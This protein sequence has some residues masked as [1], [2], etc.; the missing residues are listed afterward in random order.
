MFLFVFLKQSEMCSTTKKIACKSLQISKTFISK[1]L[2]KQT[3]RSGSHQVRN[4]FDSWKVPFC[5]HGDVIRCGWVWVVG[6]NGY[7]FAQNDGGYIWVWVRPHL[8]MGMGTNG[9]EMDLDDGNPRTSRVPK[10]L[11]AIQTTVSNSERTWSLGG[12]LT[13]K[14]R[15]RA[16]YCYF[17]RKFIHKR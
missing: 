12:C 17:Q 1:A 13:R 6:T 8:P 7:P 3:K 16:N 14:D 2:I 11:F 5:W 10:Q 15:W 4:L 9:Y